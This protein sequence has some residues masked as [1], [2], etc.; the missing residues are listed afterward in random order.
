VLIER[1]QSYATIQNRI[2]GG[3]VADTERARKFPANTCILR[4]PL[5]AKDPAIPYHE[6]VI[7]SEDRRYFGPLLF[8][9]SLDPL[10][11]TSGR[12]EAIV[13]EVYTAR[14]P[15]IGHSDA[16][17]Q[18]VV[19][20]DFQ[21]P[22]CKALYKLLTTDVLSKLRDVAFVQ[23]RN[24]PLPSHRWAREAALIGACVAEQ[25]SELFWRF[26][27]AVFARQDQLS[28]SSQPSTDLEATVRGLDGIAMDKFHDCHNSERPRKMLALDDDFIAAN[29]LSAS[30]TIFVNDFKVEGLPRSEELMS[31]ITLMAKEQRAVRTRQ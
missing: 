9:L 25:S 16:P 22:Y 13:Q 28:S 18:I 5:R 19:F 4:I 24:Y 27:D 2:R 8:D 21:C 29:G 1:I 23:F 15:V 31:M 14:A 17:V 30:P 12:R 6:T 10:D 26:S 11:V 3:V 20:S 7:V